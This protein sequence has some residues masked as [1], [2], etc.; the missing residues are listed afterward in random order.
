M[1]LLK[2]MYVSDWFCPQEQALCETCGNDLGDFLVPIDN[3]PHCE[4][5]AEARIA[6]SMRVLFVHVT[7]MVS[8]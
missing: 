8:A 7:E 5:C 1:P 3:I 4:R 6:E 2:P